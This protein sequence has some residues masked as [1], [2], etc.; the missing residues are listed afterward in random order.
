VDEEYKDHKEIALKNMSPEGLAA[1]LEK[2]LESSL[3]ELDYYTRKSE[4][5]KKSIEKL[6]KP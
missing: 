3:A 6:R 4:A 1:C 5:I 2:E